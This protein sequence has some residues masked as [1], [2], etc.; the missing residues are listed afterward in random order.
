MFFSS[1]TTHDRNT[2]FFF[3][4]SILF[5]IQREREWCYVEIKVISRLLFVCCLFVGGFGAKSV[6]D[7]QSDRFSKSIARPSRVYDISFARIALSC[8][9]IRTNFVVKRDINVI[10]WSKNY[11]PTR[12]WPLRVNCKKFKLRD[13]LCTE[14]FCGLTTINDA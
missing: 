3:T 13:R 9:V 10:E 6:S 12:S 14:S 5:I 11:N 2:W 7:P 4:S 8:I 1:R